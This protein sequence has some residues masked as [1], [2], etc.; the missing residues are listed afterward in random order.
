MMLV[1]HSMWLLQKYFQ[2]QKEKTP[3]GNRCYR[4]WFILDKKGSLYSAFCQCKGGADQGCR[5]LGAALLSLED[6]LSGNRLAVTS[7]P[8]YL[9]PTT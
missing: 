6:F 8:A 5:H 9:G 2:P 7:V 3:E 4:L 1:K